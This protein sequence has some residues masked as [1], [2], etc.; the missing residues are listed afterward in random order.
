MKK[1]FNEKTFTLLAINYVIGFGFVATIMD[2][3]KVGYWGLLILFATTLIATATAFAFSRLVNRF[4]NE[5]GGSL[6]YAKKTK[7]TYLAFFT[8]F[9]QYIQAPLFAATGPLFLVKI[10]SNLTENNTTLWSVRGVS[11]AFFTVLVLI[12]TLKMK[13][14][15]WLIFS[16]AA[17]KWITLILGFGGLIYLVTQ[18]TNSVSDNF[19]N[20]S[21]VNSYVIFSN[22]IF[23][24]FAFGGIETV[25]NI[26]HDV[27]FKNF[28][29]VLI[30]SLLVIVGFYTLG[31][32]LFLKTDLI[33]LNNGFYS[34]Y[35]NSMGI[36][37]IVAFSFY[38]F[39]YNLSSTLTSSLT[40]PAALVGL[41]NI[42]FAPKFLTKTNKYGRHRN[43][44]L[45]NALLTIV[46]MIIFTLLPE[47]LHLN[48]SIFNDVINMG[49]IAFLMQ[50]ILA[51]VTLFK[52]QKMKVI[53]K[54]PIW[55][56][57]LYYL[58]SIIIIVSSLV[59]LFPFLVGMPWTI[60]NTI[61]IVSYLGSLLIATIYFLFRRKKNRFNFNEEN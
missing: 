15:K 16:T 11:I 48:K 38:L 45:A 33:A 35:K 34:I 22:I 55:E 19:I 10:A 20:A 43:A 6:A 4:P 14:S 57:I 9:N 60:T 17:I 29:K 61:V 47:I 1:T 26:A 54:I 44:I 59:Y 32:I 27:K 41:A 53:E 40:Y 31:Y 49:T 58:A 12:S 51:F 2:I 56:Q 7:K 46:A 25:P 21:K 37:G 23:F 50:Y 36:F 30:T 24:M 13:L 3:V 28:R 5:V 18:N 42:G 39:F 52:L 8:G